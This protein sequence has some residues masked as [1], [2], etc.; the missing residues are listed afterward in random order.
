MAHLSLQ[1]Q[2]FLSANY[3]REYI[4]IALNFINLFILHF[5]VW[6][7]KYDDDQAFMKPT[8]LVF[9]VLP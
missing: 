8:A 5:F 6:I 9:F 1:L 3:T 4:W 2:A 7:K